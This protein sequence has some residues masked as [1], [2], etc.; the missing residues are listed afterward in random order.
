MAR[1]YNIAEL[2]RIVEGELRGDSAGRIDG[3]GDVVEASPSQATWVSRGQYINK[4]A[5]SRAGVVLVP[6]DFGETP[7][8]A[9]LCPRL[10]RSIAL[11][12][13]AFQET[14]AAPEPGIHA[15]AVVHQAARVGPKCAIGPYVVIDADAVLGARCRI[16]AGVLIGR[17]VRLGD[18]CEIWP[19]A[20]IRDGCNIGDRVII[21]PSAVIGADGF[22]YY[23]EGTRYIKVPHIGGVILEDDVE[24][25]AC[26]CIDR[27]K[28]GNTVIGRGTKIDNQVQIAHNVR[29]GS[30]CVLAAQVGIAGSVRIGSSCAFGGRSGA[31]D[32]LTLA[33]G[34]H[35]GAT[36]VATRDVKKAGVYTG[37]PL[38]EVS[39]AL[40][41]QAHLLRL[42][43]LAAEV[44]DLIKRVEELEAAAN[45]SS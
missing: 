14:A 32:N 39:Q 38:Q 4:L 29:V 9:I 19:N 33:D 12:L 1:S 31:T 2:A 40:R 8:P 30:D 35:I 45:D 37:S 7:M 10:D 41:T 16:H 21:H 18:D 3:V 26:A 15:T 43:E 22:G 20:V 17:G 13:A 11:L 44:K 27:A 28:F 24:V 25:G 34:V 6:R 36:S 5:A 23:R 42:S